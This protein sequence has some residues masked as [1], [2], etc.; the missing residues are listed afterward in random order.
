MPWMLLFRHVYIISTS[1]ALSL[2]FANVVPW[3]YIKN[4]V[5]CVNGSEKDEEKG[6]EKKRSHSV[7]LHCLRCGADLYV[8]TAPAGN[9]LHLHQLSPG[10]SMC[11]HSHHLLA[12]STAPWGHSLSGQLAPN[13]VQSGTG[14]K[15]A[16]TGWGR[17]LWLF[18]KISVNTGVVQL[19]TSLPH[20]GGRVIIIT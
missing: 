7:W 6:A 19:A 10:S 16:V 5:Y 3:I 13:T 17:L 8:L 2:V 15:T 14:P 20:P 4:K 11:C 1:C 12:F 9:P 18:C